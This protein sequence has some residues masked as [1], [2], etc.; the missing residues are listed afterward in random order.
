MRTLLVP[1]LIALKDNG[2]PRVL[3][4]GA[5]NNAGVP[6]T[7]L[8]SSLLLIILLETSGKILWALIQFICVLEAFISFIWLIRLSNIFSRNPHSTQR[9]YSYF[10]SGIQARRNYLPQGHAA[11]KG[12]YLAIKTL[13]IKP[14]FLCLQLLTKQ[15]L[16]FVAISN[17]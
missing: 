17:Q 11:S 16:R 3:L 1:S 9:Y 15:R 4:E 12:L 13:S 2:I 8:D 5:T 7:K 6:S 14:C 10:I